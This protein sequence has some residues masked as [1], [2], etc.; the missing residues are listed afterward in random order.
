MTA[1]W[2]RHEFS[3]NAHRYNRASLTT[4]ASQSNPN[5]KPSEPW[6]NR[7]LT[8]EELD[9]LTIRLDKMS[10]VELMKNYDSAHFV[11]RPDRGHGPRACFIQQLVAIW[12]VMRKRGLAG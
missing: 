9:E 7:A 5:S 4:V 11:C 2:P 12:R 10:D 1:N 3:V 8:R 6:I